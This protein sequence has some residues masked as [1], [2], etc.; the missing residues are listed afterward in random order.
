MD[1]NLIEKE[2]PENLNKILILKQ[3]KDSNTTHNYG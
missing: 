2:H 3:P 1:E